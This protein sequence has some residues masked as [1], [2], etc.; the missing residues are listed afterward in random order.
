MNNTVWLNADMD[1][2]KELDDHNYETLIEYSDSNIRHV[3]MSWDNSDTNYVKRILQL[4]RSILHFFSLNVS[5]KREI[6]IYKMGL[7]AGT[8]ESYDRFLYKRIQEEQTESIYKN[9]IQSIKHLKDIILLLESFGVLS[10]KDMCKYLDL[11]ESTLSEIIKKI[12]TMNLVQ[13]SRAGKFKLY[14]LTDE[15]RA[16]GKLLRRQQNYSKKEEK[17]QNNIYISNDIYIGSSKENKIDVMTSRR[18]MH[19]ILMVNKNDGEEKIKYINDSVAN[20]TREG[21][22]IEMT[23]NKYVRKGA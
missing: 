20:T 17:S 21:I 14:R 18:L 5:A 23:N 13:S 19:Y 22:I 15:G 7:L 3:V 12:K 16:L 1:L 10:H 2:I 6:A 4:G 11:K 9:K 8:V